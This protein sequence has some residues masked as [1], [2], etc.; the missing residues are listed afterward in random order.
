MST[1]AWQQL[2]CT[3]PKTLIDAVSDWLTEQGSIAVTYTDA[4][5]EAIYEP[6]PNEILLWNKTQ[7]T[8]L[9]PIEM[10]LMS[11]IDAAKLLFP[12]L[13][14]TTETLAE[15]NWIRSWMDDFKPLCFGKHTW[16]MPSNHS[17]VDNEAIN[18]LL[19]P[20][21]AFGTGTHPTTALCLE[22]LDQH[23]IKN[24][25]VV[26]YGC[27]SGILAIAAKKHGA[28]KVYAIDYDAQALIA[29]R[30]NAERNQVE[31][32]ILSPEQLPDGLVANIVLAN[33]IVGPLMD[34]EPT[35]KTLLRK[36][37]H[38]IL[39]GVLLEQQQ[40][41]VNTYEKNFHI[42]EIKYQNDWLRIE[43]VLR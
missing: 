4:G 13:T 23:D 20:G 29:T 42:N 28:K 12:E 27:G 30:E 14:F 24:K 31:I 21:L 17:I 19:D 32:E 7:L 15:Q 10:D 37:A 11:I 2:H 34:L 33:I 16:M 22:W 8:A 1:I 35:F 18:I 41:L 26:D 25:I 38:L 6:K 3:P 36:N 40:T 39:S 9:F 5:S 43:A